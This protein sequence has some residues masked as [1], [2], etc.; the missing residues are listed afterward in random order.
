MNLAIVSPYPP[1]ITGIGQYGFHLSRILAQSG[2]FLDISVL[3]GSRTKTSRVDV[4]SPMKVF[5]QWQPDRL[6]V[7]QAILADLRRRK[8]DLVWFNLGASVFG[9]SPLANLS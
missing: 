3:A 2:Q 9:R 8:P 4:T 5:Y 7:G 6:G 1:D